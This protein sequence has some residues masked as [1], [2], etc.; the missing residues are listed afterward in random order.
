MQERIFDLLE[1]TNLNWEVSK[2]PLFAGD[3]TETDTYGIFKKT[4]RKHLGSVKQR[5]EIY[6]NW[7]MAEALLMASDE[8]GVEFTKGGELYGGRKVYLQA[9]LPSE[10]IGRSSVKRYI[11]ALNSHDGSCSIGFGSSNTV[12][13][14][15][16][17]FHKAHKD[18]NKFRHTS[19][20]A[21]RIKALASDINGIILQDVM[22]MNNFKQMADMPLRDE[23]IERVIRKMFDVEANTPTKQISDQKKARIESFAGALETEIGLEGSNVWGL[24][25]AVTRFTNHIAMPQKN[26]NEY[27][28]VGA[29]HTLS[30]MTYDLLC[31]ELGLMVEA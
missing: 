17:T 31:K 25:N 30:N 29:G 14:C 28:M 27:L 1:A 20:S 22:M 3:G 24:F 12:V 5:Y 16:N 4:E 11:T 23:M 15:N 19:S 7:Q 18:T 2:E 13:V 26:K 21:E 8:V 9:E 10:Y 6:Q